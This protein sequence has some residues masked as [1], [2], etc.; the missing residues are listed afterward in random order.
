M[1]RAYR[2]KRSV[3]FLSWRESVERVKGKQAYSGKLI[4]ISKIAQE[5]NSLPEVVKEIRKGRKKGSEAERRGKEE[6]K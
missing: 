6:R 1:F 4:F 5:R 3:K 2:A